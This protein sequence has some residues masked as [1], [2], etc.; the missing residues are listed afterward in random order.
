MEFE[1]KSLRIRVET[2]GYCFRVNTHTL[3]DRFRLGCT[4]AMGL[5]KP[6]A[7]GA[8]WPA[9]PSLLPKRFPRRPHGISEGLEQPIVYC[10]FA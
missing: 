2:G 5:G 7:G 3:Q 6:I 4:N 10:T 8:K 1:G 9:A